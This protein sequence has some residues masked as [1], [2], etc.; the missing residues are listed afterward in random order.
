MLKKIRLI[1]L[2]IVLIYGIQLIYEWNSN[3]QFYKEGDTL[4]E[5]GLSDLTAGEYVSFYI[6]DYTNKEIYVDENIEYEIYT[7]LI[8]N[9]TGDNEDKYIQVM[10]KE[11]ETKQKLKNKEHSKVYFQGQVISAPY[12]GFIFNEDLFIGTDEVDYLDNDKLILTEAIVQT[13][14]Q[15]EGYGL[16]V[17][18]ALV[19]FSLIAYRKFGGIEGCVPDVVIESNKYDEYNLEY[20]VQTFNIRNEWQCEKDNLKKLQAEQIENKKACNVLIVVFILGLIFYCSIP[21]FFIRIFGF[22]P[23]FIG[24]GG[25]W[26][27]FINSS[28]KLAVY[29]AKKREKR[30]IYL[31]TEVCKK[32]IEE[33]ER[34]MEEKNL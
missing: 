18:I 17:G 21:V 12:G 25:V 19:F 14:L 26:S 15:D 11:Q 1:I 13:E 23:M 33:L 29:I 10:V 27:R 31:E 16:Y 28:H 32:N 2:L 34:I 24:I 6:D 9:G 5:I 4:E 7:I 8:E 20:S 22:I 3:R 30:S